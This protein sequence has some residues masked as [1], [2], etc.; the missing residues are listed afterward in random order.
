M[1][2]E[3]LTWRCG[4]NG[5]SSATARISDL[6]GQIWCFALRP[7]SSALNHLNGSLR[8]IVAV[9]HSVLKKV[10]DELVSQH[11]LSERFS[12]IR[13]ASS[14]PAGLDSRRMDREGRGPQASSPEGVA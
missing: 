5:R 11:A 6:D 7:G 10:H 13:H 12:I 2:C 3:L 1:P 8:H 4:L 14:S 9:G